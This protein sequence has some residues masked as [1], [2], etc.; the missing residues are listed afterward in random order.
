MGC[1]ELAGAATLGRRGWTRWG[2][3]WNSAGYRQ[4][5]AFDLNRKSDGTGCAAAIRPIE[6]ELADARS[7]GILGRMGAAK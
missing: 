2:R 5:D 3:K 1:Y 6:S 7:V 4:T